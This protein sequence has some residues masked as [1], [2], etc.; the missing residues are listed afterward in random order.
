MQFVR[1][2]Y[3][4]LALLGFLKLLSLLRIYDNI[5]FI[6]KMLGIVVLELLPFLI[7]FIGF[8]GT[9]AVVITAL[10]M[11]VT[12][13][14]EDRDPYSGLGGMAY[15][16]FVLRTSFGDFAVDSFR[17]MPTYQM[18]FTWTVWLVVIF[19]NTIVF[20]NFIIA[21]ISDTYE[22]IMDTRLEEIYQK[23][24]KLLIDMQSVFGKYSSK[25]THILITRTS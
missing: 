3:S 12:Y 2:T 22:Q 13:L 21:V 4:V 5:S 15:F 14:E 11:D 18:Y 10:D 9:F 24:A 17:H 6:I 7:L 20:L 8:G 19:C 16:F 23:K 25:R 1:I